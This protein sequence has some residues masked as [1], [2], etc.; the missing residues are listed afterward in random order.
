MSFLGIKVY[1]V[2]FYADLDNPN[3]KVNFSLVSVFLQR[4]LKAKQIAK[5]ATPEEKIDHIS[6]NTACVIRIS[7]CLSPSFI[8]RITDPCPSSYA[9]NVV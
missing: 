2:G 3:L 9:I 8:I 7:V 6:R 1:S 5:S 4:S